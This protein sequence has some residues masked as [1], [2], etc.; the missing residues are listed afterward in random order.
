ME[1]NDNSV[2]PRTCSLVPFGNFLEDV[3]KSPVTGWRWRR[4]GFITTINVA[5]KVYVTQDEIERFEKRAIAGEFSKPTRAPRRE[6][7]VCS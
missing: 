4:D 3:G 7:E 5:G 6:K 1:C 2:R